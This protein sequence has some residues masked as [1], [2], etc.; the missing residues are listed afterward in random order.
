MRVAL[1]VE[2]L[3]ILAVDVGVFVATPGEVHEENLS[4][5]VRRAADGF[6]DGVGGFERRDDSLRAGEARA[7][8]ERLAV[9]R[10]DVLGAALVVQ[11]GVLRSDAG[12][13]EA[14]GDRVRQRHSV[15]RYP[16]AGSCRRL[17]GRPAAAGKAAACSPSSRAPPA[18]FDADQ[19][20]VPDPRGTGEDADGIASAAH[21]GT[22]RPAGV[23]SA[24][25]HLRPRFVADH[26]LEVAHHHRI[27][28]RAESGTEQV[29]GV[30]DVG[31]P[32]A[33]GLADGVLQRA[34]CRVLTAVTRAP[35][36]RIRKTLSACRRMS[37]SPI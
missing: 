29:V 26:A 31:H 13:V 33:H 9:G 30:A 16:A 37:S 6:R 10:R 2:F 18:R 3:H 23:P 25:Q 5:C 8:R 11:P 24:F 14:G 4:G 15:R 21:A 19:P 28:M 35:S 32:I 1:T 17:A 7:P 27:G 20:D 12:V 22:D 34:C 36:S